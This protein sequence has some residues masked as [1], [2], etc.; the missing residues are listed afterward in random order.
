MKFL[1]NKSF[2]IIDQ[3]GFVRKSLEEFFNKFDIKVYS[4]DSE[5]Q[6]FFHFQKYQIDIALFNID[7][8][9]KGSREILGKVRW[10]FPYVLNILVGTSEHIT[11]Y[12]DNVIFQGCDFLKF[13]FDET[14]LMEILKKGLSETRGGFRGRKVKAKEPKKNILSGMLLSNNKSS[15]AW[16]LNYKALISYRKQYSD[17]WPKCRELWKQKHLGAWVS[18]QR[19]NYRNKKAGEFSPLSEEQIELLNRISFPWEVTCEN[20]NE[21]FEKLKAFRQEFP[22]R[23]PRCWGGEKELGVW[24]SFQRTQYKKYLKGEKNFLSDEKLALLKEINF[25][26]VFEKK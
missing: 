18:V 4:V 10:S 3:E 17:K 2:L 14:E 5:S 16:M 20:W 8:S 12:C 25:C 13:P 21:K 26:W 11:K 7:L 15:Q 24:C 19:R 6:A 1:L 23:W 22:D 9:N